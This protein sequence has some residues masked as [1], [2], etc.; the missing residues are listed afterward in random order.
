[1]ARAPLQPRGDADWHAAPRWERQEQAQ[2]RPELHDP[3]HA[4]PPQN[5]G[6]G[7]DAAI[8]R[9]A[10]RP[11]LRHAR[12]LAHSPG[13]HGLAQVRQTRDEAQRALQP[14]AAL[15]RHRRLRGADAHRQRQGDGLRRGVHLRAARGRE[16]GRAALDAASDRGGG[17]GPAHCRRR[18]RHGYA[19]RRDEWAHRGDGLP[20]RSR[21]R[22]QHPGQVRVHSE[23]VAAH[24]ALRRVRD[25][26]GAVARG[27]AAGGGVGRLQRRHRQIPPHVPLLR[28]DIHLHFI[29]SDLF[30]C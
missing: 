28:L 16:R 7:R 4:Q 11:L 2:I 24:G 22:H 25:R 8:N 17:R 30:T 1:M 21:R 20:A 13:T 27:V 12:A 9:G 26:H 23:G 15:S 29:P 14:S 18:R 10:P 19:L 3:L 6:P 5:P